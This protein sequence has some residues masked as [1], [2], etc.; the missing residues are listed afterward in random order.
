MNAGDDRHGAEVEHE[1]DAF[2]EQRAEAFDTFLKNES[3]SVLLNANLAA[4]LLVMVTYLNYRKSGLPVTLYLYLPAVGLLLLAKLWHALRPRSFI[5]AARPYLDAFCAAAVAGATLVAVAFAR[6]NVESLNAPV[7]IALVLTCA[8]GPY[9]RPRSNY[10]RSLAIGAGA[11]ALLYG[12]VPDYALKIWVQYPIGVFLG[13]AANRYLLENRKQ[14]FFEISFARHGH[15]HAL[16]QLEKMLLPHQTARISVGDALEDT[17][18][19]GFGN[20]YVIMFDVVGSSRIHHDKFH[21]MLHKTFYDCYGIMMEGYRQV[22]LQANG[23]PIKWLGDGFLCSVGFPLAAPGAGPAADVADTLGELFCAA[24]CANMARLRYHDRVCCAMGV[25]R[26][27]IEGFYPE[28]GPKHYDLRGTSSGDPIMLSTRYQELRKM[29]LP[30]IGKR[31][32]VMT[33]GES[34]FLSL[35]PERRARYEAWPV[36]QPRNGVRDDPGARIAYYRLLPFVEAVRG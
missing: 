30:G 26:G 29:I 20:A 17:M 8:F 5:G 28:N 24:F 15:A 33:I 19:V 31:E 12:L 13:S 36:S 6:H 3:V 22:P 9:A 16:K 32:S 7:Q 10:I 25:A 23:Y 27:T 18:P 21:D 14:Q 2:C 4:L 1:L 35:A 34:V 11:F